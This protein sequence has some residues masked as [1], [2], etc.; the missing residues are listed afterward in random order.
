MVATNLID[1][2]LD[3]VREHVAAARFDLLPMLETYIGE[4]RFGRSFIDEDL[5]RLS[6]GAAVLEVG[7]GSLLLSCQLV[8][9][10]LAVTALEPIA[11]GFSH[12]NSLQALVLARASEIGCAP[13]L[14]R[15]D[16]EQLTL[17]EQFDFAF[18]INVMEHVGV[19]ARVIEN[20]T[21]SLRKGATYRFVC[22]NYHFPY[23][24]HFKIPTLFSKPLTEKFLRHKIFAN[25]GLDD[26][27]GVWNS[28]NWITV[29]QVRRIVGRIADV[30]LLFHRDRLTAT[31]NRIV[32]D[33]TF[34]QRQPRWLRSVLLIMV[35]LRIHLMFSAI[36][37]VFQP[38]MDC[39]ITKA[40]GSSPR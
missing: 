30:S 39:A 35:R 36:P 3:G 33:P 20:V 19:V 2:W 29:S 27:G 15:L 31:V 24:P 21:H 18:S 14:L 38:I 7:A 8:R 4:A 1:E 6:R 37:A 11:G 23:E 40:P 5:S 17:H 9:E 32:T 16:G 22:P 34:S 25:V 12:F 28:L 26:P 10:G 13:V